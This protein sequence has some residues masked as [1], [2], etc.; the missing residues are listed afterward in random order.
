MDCSSTNGQPLGI[1]EYVYRCVKKITT[2]KQT[3]ITETS[4]R[5]DGGEKWEDICVELG[6]GVKSFRPA[7]YIKSDDAVN[8]VDIAADNFCLEIF[9]QLVPGTLFSSRIIELKAKYTTYEMLD[10]NGRTFKATSFDGFFYSVVKSGES[11][12]EARYIKN[13]LTEFL[14]NI[15]DDPCFRLDEVPLTYSDVSD[16]LFCYSEEKLKAA[17]PK[18]SYLSLHQCTNLKTFIEWMN[19]D[20]FRL[21][22]AWAYAAVHPTSVTSN[23]ALLLWTGGGTGKS[24]FVAMI[25]EAICM[26]S[27]AKLDDVYFEIKGNRFDEDPRNWVPDGE[28]GLGKAALVNVDEATTKTIELYKDFSGSAAGNVL[29]TRRNYENT[30]KHIVKGKFIFTTN[31]GLQLTNDDGS[32]LRRVAII[33][34]NESRNTVGR[35]VLPNEKIVEEYRKQVYMMLRLGKQALKE[36][37]EMGYDT[38]DA[39]A[40]SCENITKNLK[41]STAT[42]MNVQIYDWVW[43]LALEKVP[44][45]KQID[46]TIRMKGNVLKKLYTDSCLENGEDPKYFGSFKSFVIDQFQHFTAPNEHTQTRNFITYDP[47]CDVFGMKPSSCGCIYVLHPLKHAA[48]EELVIKTD[49]TATEEEDIIEQLM[50]E[51]DK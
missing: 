19:P 11:L 26:A 16:A 44:D 24:S 13:V 46:G 51:D 21:A 48:E 39:Y 20:E 29:Q 15:K 40:M 32:L 43:D 5:K 8:A 49:D 42:S 14:A 7:D 28:V 27:G 45:C 2:L 1:D 25:R 23:I 4:K 18:D 9:W 36:I 35:E 12:T 17:L 37:K 22:M 10:P 6:D 33:K 3:L 31:K 34:H 41:E 50:H 38:L 47:D 30:I